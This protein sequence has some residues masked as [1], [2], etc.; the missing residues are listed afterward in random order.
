MTITVFPFSTKRLRTAS[1]RLMS[2]VWRPVVGSSRDIEGLPGGDPLELTGQFHPLGLPT[3]QG[4]GR[5]AQRDV[6]EPHINNGLELTAD[7]RLGGEE[8]QRLLNLHVQDL[9]DV[10]PLVVDLE[11]F[12][13]IPGP[14]ADVAVD[15]NIRKEVHL[16]LDN[17][18]S[19]AG[20]APPAFDVKAEPALGIAT[21]LSL[22]G[23]GKQF[24]DIVKDRGCR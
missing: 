4:W 21:H 5:L 15:I 9:G 17:P 12:R 14:V 22:V 11:G 24:P 13:I 6:T 2:S 7:L 18:V 16:D 19:F 1:R 20:L 3:G 10:L 23:L 8:V